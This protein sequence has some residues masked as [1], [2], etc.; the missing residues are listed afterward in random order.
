[1]DLL[2]RCFAVG[3]PEE[4]LHIMGQRWRNFLQRGAAV[5]ACWFAL[6]LVR[7]WTFNYLLVEFSLD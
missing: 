5:V 2:L 7:L 4:S 3:E 1:M 6:H